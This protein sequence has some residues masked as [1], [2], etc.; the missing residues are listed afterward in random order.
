M[1]I[2]KLMTTAV[3]IGAVAMTS[4]SPVS[5]AN[6]RNTAAAAGLAGGLLLGGLI[7]SQYRQS[8]PRYY[9]SHPTYYYAPPPR[10][11]YY[12]PY[13]PAISYCMRRFRSYDPYSM[14]YI[15]YDGY[16][17]SCP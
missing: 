9:A 3:V 10:P 15:G 1:K 8:G 17:H 5:A 6:G 4:V 16:R 14:T 13:D 2:S 12:E 7:G 11:V